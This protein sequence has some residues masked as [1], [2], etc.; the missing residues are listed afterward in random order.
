VG[1]RRGLGF[2]DYFSPLSTLEIYGE[3]RDVKEEAEQLMCV[4]MVQVINRGVELGMA[5]VYS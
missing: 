3:I 4:W 1:V 2:F 5:K